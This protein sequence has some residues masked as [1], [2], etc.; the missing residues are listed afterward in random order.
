MKNTKREYPI[1]DEHRRH[2]VLYPIV[3][4]EK[5]RAGDVM[6]NPGGY[7]NP[8][9]NPAKVEFDT[10]EECQKACDIHNSFHGWDEN[11]VEEIICESMGT[12]V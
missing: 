5:W 9:D 11:D 7:R 10:E 3:K 8:F 6:L 4:G 2:Y 1:K 12:T